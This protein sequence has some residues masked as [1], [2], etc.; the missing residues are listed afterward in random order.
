MLLVAHSVC[1]LLAFMLLESRGASC[2]GGRE[3]LLG[4]LPRLRR[5]RALSSCSLDVRVLS[6]TSGSPGR[7]G[8]QPKPAYVPCRMPTASSLLALPTQ[9]SSEKILFLLAIL[10]GCSQWRGRSGNPVFSIYGNER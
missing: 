10:S 1:S 2:R 7:V 5:P 9:E 3:A 6:A 4:S 8:P